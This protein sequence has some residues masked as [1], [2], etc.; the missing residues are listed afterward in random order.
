MEYWEHMRRHV[1][2]FACSEC[3]FV[4]KYKHHMNHHWLSVHDG[5][6]PF[7]CKKCSYTCVSKSMLASH[8]KKHS[9]VYPYRCADCTYKTKFCNALKKHL[10]KKEHRPAMVLNADGSPNPSSVIDV[11]GT[12]RGPKRK[13]SAMEREEERGSTVATTTANDRLDSTATSPLLP[14]RSP[15]TRCLTVTKAIGGANDDRRIDRNGTNNDRF[16]ATFPYSDL[17]A[18]FDLSSHVSFREDATFYDDTWKTDRSRS[19]VTKERARI[20]NAEDDVPETFT[21]SLPETHLDA[22]HLNDVDGERRFDSAKITSES[23]TTFVTIKTIQLERSRTE[24]ADVPLDLRMAEV[25]G[26]VNRLRSRTLARIGSAISPRV[27]GTSKRKGKAIKLERL[28]VKD[29]AYERPERNEDVSFERPS[30]DRADILEANRRIE[31]TAEDE[32][33]A[34]LFDVELTCRYCEIIFGNVIMH[35]V[36]MSCHSFDDPYTCDICGQRCVDKLSFFLHIARS[37]H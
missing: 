12:K 8:S 18:A 35:A 17:V 16:V 11:Y 10:R 25:I 19:G 3:S 36:H 9:N 14:L 27:T 20:S 13:L 22:T 24:S 2:G 31:D 37:E 32:A 5:S 30:D 29:D 33:V 28:M 15:I 7:K 26:R 4:T 21:P 6:K 23:S 34:D 1:K